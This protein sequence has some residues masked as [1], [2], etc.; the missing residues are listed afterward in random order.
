[1]SATRLWTCSAAGSLIADLQ[2]LVEGTETVLM[3]ISSREYTQ[4]CGAFMDLL[5]AEQLRHIGQKALTEAV[6][7]A[8]TRTLGDAWAW[9]RRG[10]D[11]D[12]TPLVAVTLALAGFRAHENDDDSVADPWIWFG[13]DDEDD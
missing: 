3:E 2:V 12:I 10:K 7:G 5:E 13:D 6:E 4:A 11:V 8:A 9:D 1:M